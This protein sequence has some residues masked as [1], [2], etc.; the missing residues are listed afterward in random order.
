MTASGNARRSP[1]SAD[2]G[3]D[4]DD[5]A[6]LDRDAAVAHG[7]PLDRDDPVGRVD[8]PAGTYVSEPAAYASRRAS[9]CA[10]QRFSSRTE[11]QIE[12]SKRRRSGTTSKASETGSTVGR[13]IATTRTLT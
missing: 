8:G 9:I 2:G 11:A 6:V 4:R 3:P 10:A 1:S 5:A 12:S 7:R 13:M